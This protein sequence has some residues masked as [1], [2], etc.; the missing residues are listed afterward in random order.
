MAG[1]TDDPHPIFHVHPFGASSETDERSD[2][3]G[4]FQVPT[5]GPNPIVLRTTRREDV[6]RH[7]IS[8][9]QN[10]ACAGLLVAMAAR[11]IVIDRRA[12]PDLFS[13]GKNFAPAAKRRLQLPEK[14]IYF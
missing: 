8:P 12:I 3:M 7:A 6:I 5:G 13:I 1:R 4:T 10:R 11:G 9:A 2:L 14:G